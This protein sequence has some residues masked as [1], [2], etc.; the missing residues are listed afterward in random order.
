LC[1]VT[2]AVYW[3]TSHFGFVAL[4]DDQ[5]VYE[6]PHVQA[7]LTISGVAWAWT[8]FFYSYWHPLTWISL[9]LDHQ[10]FGANPGGFHLMNVALHMAATVLLLLALLRMT[11]CPW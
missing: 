1:L 3:Q 2:A 10:L 5:Y 7:G 9:M 11:H 6:N 4:D 8:T